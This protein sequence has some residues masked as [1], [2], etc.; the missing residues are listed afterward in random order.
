MREFCRLWY[1]GLVW[2]TT[3]TICLS[4]TK[5]QPDWKGKAGKSGESHNLLGDCVSLSSDETIAYGKRNEEE[6]TMYYRHYY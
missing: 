1:I 4:I 5:V 3:L 2:G 6:Y